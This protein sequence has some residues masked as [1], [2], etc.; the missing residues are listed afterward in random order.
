MTVE[1]PDRPVRLVLLDIEGTTTPIAFVYDVLFPFARTHLSDWCHRFQ[2]S[3]E[4]EDVARRLADEHRADRARG[5]AVPEW[6]DDV[7]ASVEA[8][9]TWLMDRDRKSPA[10]KLLQGLVWEQGYQ[11]GALRG[12]VYP[13]VPEAI[14]QWRAGGCLVAIYSS[15]SALA[16]RRLFES[17]AYGDLAPLLAGFFDTTVGSKLS[18]ESYGRIAAELGVPAAAALFISDVTAELHAAREAGCQTALSVRPGNRP[19]PDAYLFPVVR[20]LTD[21]A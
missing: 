8:Y 3:P 16:Q 10:L 21:I 4:F 14:R 5:E 9:A 17:T 11:A 6:R 20:S 13:D 15:G 1:L 12:Q 7:L 19:Q 18:A 2:H